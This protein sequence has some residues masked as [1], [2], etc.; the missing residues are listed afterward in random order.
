MW[1]RVFRQRAYIGI[2][3][4]RMRWYVRKELSHMGKNNRNPDL[5]CGNIRKYHECEEGI[6]FRPKDH[7]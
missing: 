1:D 4:S 5:V 7:R 6:E 3:R 2:T